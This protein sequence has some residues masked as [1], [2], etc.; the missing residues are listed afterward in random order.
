[1]CVSVIDDMIVKPLTVC[2]SNICW[3]TVSAIAIRFFLKQVINKFV[4]TRQDD[5]KINKT[6]HEHQLWNCMLLNLKWGGV[7]VFIDKMNHFWYRKVFIQG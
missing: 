2:L 1:M 6:R 3:I 5:W 4:L 7:C